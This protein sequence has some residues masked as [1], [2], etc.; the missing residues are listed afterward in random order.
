MLKFAMQFSIWIDEKSIED[1]K[2]NFSITEEYKTTVVCK[3]F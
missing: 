3:I 2:D 1:S